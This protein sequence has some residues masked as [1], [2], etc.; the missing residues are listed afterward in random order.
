MTVNRAGTERLARL[1]H[2]GNVRRP[3]RVIRNRG[4][5][6]SGGW[7]AFAVLLPFKTAGAMGDGRIY[8]YVVGLRRIE[9]QGLLN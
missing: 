5:A 3:A 1:R 9:K 7:Q 4:R 6:Q 2:P 8:E